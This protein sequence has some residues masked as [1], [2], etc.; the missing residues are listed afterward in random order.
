MIKI[1]IAGAT[2]YVGIEL[3]RLLLGHPEI[4]LT[5]LAANTNAGEHLHH[6]YPHI[7]VRDQVRVICQELDPNKMADSCEIVFTALSHGLS[8][9]IASSL[10]DRGLKLID[11]SADFR[12]K[13]PQKFRD[14]Y[15]H[16]PANR[17]LLKQ[18][19]YG[20]P[21]ITGRKKIKNSNLIACPGCYPTSVA[22]AAAPALK[23]DIIHTDRLIFDSK[24]GVSGAGRSAI[25]TSLFCEVSENIKAYNLA[26]MHRHTPEIEQVL[27]QIVKKN[28]NVQFTPH[29]IPMI[30]GMLTTAYMPLKKSISEFEIWEIYQNAYKNEP[31]IRLHPLGQLPQAADVRCSNYC[32]LGLKLDNR[33]GNL[34]VVSVIDN[35]IKGAAG[36]AI[37]NMNILIGLPETTGLEPH[38]S[39]YP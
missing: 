17:K 11:L 23:A 18:A 14:W 10:L 3:V 15:N 13:D 34:I 1:G 25:Q 19:C 33:T 12:L 36:Q 4:Q 6:L 39:P 32:D 22:I 16:E 29:L 28:I 9:K 2:G 30:R 5:Y 7:N 24:S 26:G 20:L 35:L 8:M 21:E 27:S 31:F 38:I 37:Q